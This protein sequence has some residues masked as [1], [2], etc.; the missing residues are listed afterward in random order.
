MLIGYFIVKA[1]PAVYVLNKQVEEVPDGAISAKAM[2]MALSA[3]VSISVGRAMV[4]V[5]TGVS[6]IVAAE[7]SASNQAFVMHAVA[8]A[9]SFMYFIT[10]H[11]ITMTG[12]TVRKPSYEEAVEAGYTPCS[13]CIK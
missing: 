13:S 8:L 7:M 12:S 6:A 10:Q 4:R 11:P 2:G 5:L 1:E 9:L 3:G